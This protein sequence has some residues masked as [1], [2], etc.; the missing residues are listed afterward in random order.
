MSSSYREGT[1]TENE[2][3][4]NS[5]MARQRTVDWGFGKFINTFAFID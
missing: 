3:V 5:N 4:F 1:H 2:E